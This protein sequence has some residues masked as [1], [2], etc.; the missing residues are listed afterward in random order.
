MIFE[1]SLA[2]QDPVIGGFQDW[3]S[4]NFSAQ[5]LAQPELVHPLATPDGDGIANVIRYALGIPR[6]P[7]NPELLPHASVVNAVLG[8]EF[9]MDPALTDIAYIVEASDTLDPESWTP[10]FHS[11]QDSVDIQ[12]RALLRVEDGRPLNETHPRQFL[13]LRIDYLSN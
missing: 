12:E 9:S 3:L 1:G 13:R 5:E 2:A 10:V 7:A 4:A 6:G 8:L 11:Q